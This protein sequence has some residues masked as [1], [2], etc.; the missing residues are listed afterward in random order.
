MVCMIF[1][2]SFFIYM[3]MCGLL[4]LLHPSH[5]I[6]WLVSWYELFIQFI[7]CHHVT[8][9]HPHMSSCDCHLPHDIVWLVSST[10][11]HHVTCV[12]HLWR[13]FVIHHMTSCDFMWLSSTTWHHVTC[14]IHRMTCDC[15]IHHMW[16]CVIHHMT[17]CE[18]CVIHHVTCCGITLVSY[19]SGMSNML[20]PFRGHKIVIVIRLLGNQVAWSLVNSYMYLKVTFTFWGEYHFNFLVSEKTNHLIIILWLMNR[21][22]N[23]VIFR[24]LY[25]LVKPVCMYKIVPIC[26]N[27]KQCSQK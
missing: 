4:W 6:L 12:I 11:W 14:V 22:R 10:T 7:T 9:C 5:D 1:S 2:V 16:H 18:Y 15:V 21:Y 17:S 3:T 26:K 13:D 8:L 23:M 20:M 24:R 25:K 27:F 19:R